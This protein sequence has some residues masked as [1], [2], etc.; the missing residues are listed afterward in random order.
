MLNSFPCSADK[1]DLKP[2][3]SWKNRCFDDKPWVGS[4]D[5]SEELKV[6]PEI[7]LASENK[8]IKND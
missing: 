6:E 8:D 4:A 7:E 3:F 2:D 5:E 1:N